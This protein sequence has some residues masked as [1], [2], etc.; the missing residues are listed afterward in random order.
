MLEKLF[1]FKRENEESINKDII[2]A[3]QMEMRKWTY[4]ESLMSPIW[5]KLTKK[6]NVINSDRW[7]TFEKLKAEY[8]NYYVNGL[9]DGA[10]VGL[11]MK[12][13]GT[14]Y[15]YYSRG[16]ARYNVIK[17]LIR[18]LDDK[19]SNAKIIFEKYLNRGESGRPWLQKIDG[20]YYNPEVFDHFLFYFFIESSI[21][22]DKNLRV[23]TT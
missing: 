10:D 20:K 2:N 13:F 16:L 12:R 4:D 11:E 9:S 21:K 17:N 15:K 23:K 7:G 14:L 1:G 5:K 19:G 3:L 6:Y 8:E 18:F 22:K